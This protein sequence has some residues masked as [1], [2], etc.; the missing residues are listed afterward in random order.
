MRELTVE[1]MQQV[2]GGLTPIEGASLIASLSMF[3]PVT[4]AFGIPIAGALVV[5]DYLSN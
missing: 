5:V 3:S 2:D 4:F 1:E